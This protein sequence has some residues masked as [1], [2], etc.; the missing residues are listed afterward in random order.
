MR[1]TPARRVPPL[2]PLKSARAFCSLTRGK[3]FRNLSAYLARCSC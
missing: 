3:L 2:R 1:H